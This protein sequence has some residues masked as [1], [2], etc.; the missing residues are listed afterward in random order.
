[1]YNKS[2]NSDTGLEAYW[3]F[4]NPTKQP[5]LMS[6]VL[7]HGSL[8]GTVMLPSHHSDMVIAGPLASHAHCALK[9]VS[10]P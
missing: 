3:V 9:P 1:M 5:L 2:P 6:A 7:S 4:M 8:A 10:P